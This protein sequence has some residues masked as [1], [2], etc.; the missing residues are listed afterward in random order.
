MGLLL[1]VNSICKQLS[2]WFIVAS[3]GTLYHLYHPRRRGYISDIVT[4]I[5]YIDFYIT[6]F[7]VFQ[8]YSVVSVFQCYSVVSVFQCYSVVSIFQCYSVVFVFQCYSVVYIPVL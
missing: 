2:K 4:D 7:S 3:L 5:A 6:V 8:C 1:H